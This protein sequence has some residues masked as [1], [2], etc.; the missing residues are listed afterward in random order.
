M[1]EDETFENEEL[2]AEDREPIREPTRREKYSILAVAGIA[3]VM[4]IGMCLI[5]LAIYLTR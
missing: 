5:V 4:L 1:V 2:E 3:Y